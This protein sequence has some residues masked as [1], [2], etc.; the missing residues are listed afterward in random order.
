ML[1]LF[2]LKTLDLS[3][4]QYGLLA[5][6]FPVG[7]L[8]RYFRWKIYQK[9]R[10]A[11]RLPDCIDSSGF[12][13][14]RLRLHA[15]ADRRM[16]LNADL[17]NYFLGVHYV[18][19]ADSAGGNARRIY[20]PDQ[21]CVGPNDGDDVRDVDITRVA[22][23]IICPRAWSARGQRCSGLYRVFIIFGATF[24]LVGGGVMYAAQARAKQSP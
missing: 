2:G 14:Y 13:L 22:G 6:M 18:S 1:A 7:N 11:P 20:G 3:P 24:L 23:S 12:G 19:G 8:Q 9:A 15:T 21:C 16:R 5:M 10:H 17:W 4:A